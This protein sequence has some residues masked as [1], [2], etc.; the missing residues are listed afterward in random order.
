M[1]AERRRRRRQAARASA[2][3]GRR[4]APARGRHCRH[5]RA[6]RTATSCS[7]RLRR[8]C[9]G[10]GHGRWPGELRGAAGVRGALT[11]TLARRR[12]TA[13]SPVVDVGGMSTEIA[14]RDDG[15][16][17]RP[18]ARSL[19]DRVERR[20]SR[21]RLCGDPPSPDDMATMR[22]ARVGAAF[23]VHGYAASPT[24]RPSRSAA[25]PSSL[26]TIVGSSA[27]PRVSLEGALARIARLRARRRRSPGCTISLPERV[28]SCFPRAGPWCSARPQRATGQRRC[29][30]AA[31]DCVRA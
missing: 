5:P 8:A 7:R 22:A 18:G 3:V 17:R 29:G 19:R 1:I 24:H 28:P 16:W 26:P 4:R 20:W 11:R 6:R 21:P 27:R 14:V 15:L 25:A 31:A 30:S 23:V 9:G 13:R 12:R 10:G 2:A